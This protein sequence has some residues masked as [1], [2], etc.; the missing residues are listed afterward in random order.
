METKTILDQVDELDRLIH[1]LQKMESQMQVGRWL[2]A[3]RGCCRLISAFNKAK[4]DL[5]A[6][7]VKNEE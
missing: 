4:I 5:I 2:D 3:H 1:Q 6:N 7:G